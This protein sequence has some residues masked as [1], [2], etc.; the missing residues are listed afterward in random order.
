MKNFLITF[1]GLC[2]TS[3]LLSLLGF[4]LMHYNYWHEHGFF[5]LIF[6]AFFPRLTLLFS[7]I[8]F[9]GIFWWLGFIFCPRYL[10]A[11]L[12]TVNYW[13]RNPILVTFAWLIAI[14]GEST[15]KYYIRRRVYYYR[16]DEIAKEDI[17]DVEAEPIDKA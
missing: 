4:D 2:V 13:H 3:V 11:L 5:L 12:A 7:S 16:K 1:I 10:V 14:G 6:L 17:I 15:E 9:G 8:P